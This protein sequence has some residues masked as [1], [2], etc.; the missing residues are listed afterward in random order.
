MPLCGRQARMG[1]LLWYNIGKADYYTTVMPNGSPLA[2]QPPFDGQLYHIRE[3]A[4]YNNHKMIWG[5]LQSVP[6]KIGLIV[7]AGIR[8]I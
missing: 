5:R 7:K 4:W 6:L 1:L 3:A 8:R 2:R